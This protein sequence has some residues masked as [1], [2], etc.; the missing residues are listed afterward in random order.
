MKSE[1]IKKMIQEEFGY[2]KNLLSERKM[3]QEQL[4]ELGDDFRVDGQMTTSNFGG[5]EV[6]MDDRGD[7][8][9][10]RHNYGGVP[11][12]P[13]DAEIEF[14]I[15]DDEDLDGKPYFMIG[16]EKYYLDQFM[17]VRLEEEEEE[18]EETSGIGTN[19]A[20]KHSAGHKEELD[21]EEID[22]IM[23]VGQGVSR[24]AGRRQDTLSKKGLRDECMN[25]SMLRNLV[26]NQLKKDFLNEGHKV[27]LGTITSKNGNEWTVKDVNGKWKI[28]REKDSLSLSAYKLS[29][30]AKEIMQKI[31]K[32]E[33]TL[34]DFKQLKKDIKKLIDL[35]E[36]K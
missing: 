5:I 23:G 12:E 25:E 6:E 21:E 27:V 32:A 7:G 30:E 14:E 33:V 8:L 24:R 28:T 4:S 18:I 29:D 16:D 10:Y 20:I 22:E 11:D 15:S 36:E 13:Q 35:K 3:I 34:T 1:D 26:K 31:D 17:R 9:R 2:I 19:L